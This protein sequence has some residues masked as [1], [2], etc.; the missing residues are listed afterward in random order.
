VK[1]SVRSI[2]DVTAIMCLIETLDASA[3]MCSYFIFTIGESSSMNDD[4]NKDNSG[5]I[6]ILLL[7]YFTLYIA[8]VWIGAEAKSKVCFDLIVKLNFATIHVWICCYY[9]VRRGWQFHY[10]LF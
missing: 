5:A 2:T 9:K 1:K 7:I 8:M 6:R 10:R 3:E 4:D